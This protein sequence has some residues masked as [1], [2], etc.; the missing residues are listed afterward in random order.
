MDQLIE[1]M[2]AVGAGLAPIDGAGV[3]ADFSAFERYMFAVAFHRQLLQVGWEALEV[4]LIGQDGNGLRVEE[5]G[6]PD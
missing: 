3:V 6:V 5:I 4:L 1:G 2:L